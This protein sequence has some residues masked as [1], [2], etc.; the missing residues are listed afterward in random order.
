MKLDGVLLEF[1]FFE[2]GKEGGLSSKKISNDLNKFYF[3]N[4]Q[5]CKNI[6]LFFFSLLEVKKKRIELR[7]LASPV[8]FIFKTGNLS[9]KYVHLMLNYK[10]FSAC[11]K[12]LRIMK[13]K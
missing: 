10:S 7:K 8:I 9:N 6:F 2:R 11:Y 5:T 13:F 3:E 12:I 1:F 4:V